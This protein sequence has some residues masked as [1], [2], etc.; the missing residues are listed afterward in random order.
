MTQFT[1]V[2]AEPAACQQVS[3]FAVIRF[4]T[5]PLANARPGS[6]NAFARPEARYHAF[7]PAASQRLAFIR[8]RTRPLANA[9]PGSPNAFA[10]PQARYHAFEPAASQRLSSY[11]LGRDRRAQGRRMR[12]LTPRQATMHSEAPP[13]SLYRNLACFVPVRLNWA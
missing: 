4:R 9:R 6:P 7:E 10:R 8:F 2:E 5:R 3:S 11:A 13:P 1:L 12:S